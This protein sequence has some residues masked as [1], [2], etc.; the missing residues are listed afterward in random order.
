NLFDDDTF[1]PCFG[2]SFVE[3]TPY[4]RLQVHS[5]FTGNGGQPPPEL[6]EYVFLGRAF[7]LVGDFGPPDITVSVYW[8][9]SVRAWLRD[10]NA[11]FAVLPAREASFAIMTTVEAMAAAELAYLW[12]SERTKMADGLAQN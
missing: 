5:V 1:K 2:I 3:M 8:Q 9:R 10:V 11:V 4:Q 7:A 12:P 6:P